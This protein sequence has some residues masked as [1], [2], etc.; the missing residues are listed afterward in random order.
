MQVNIKR[1]ILIVEKTH[2]GFEVPGRIS[3]VQ[4]ITY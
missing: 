3:F 1:D 4:I 2:R